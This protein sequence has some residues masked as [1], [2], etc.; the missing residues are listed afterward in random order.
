[1][2]KL[3][4]V[5]WLS[6]LT[7]SL[8]L[9][10]LIQIRMTGRTGFVLL[11]ESSSPMQLFASALFVSSLLA[12]LAS[13]I[14]ALAYSQQAFWY[15]RE[16]PPL[17][18]AAGG[19]LYVAGVTLAL[20]SQLTLGRSWRI[21]VDAS[22]RTELVV[23]GAFKV[24]RNPVFSALLLTSISLAMLCSTPLAWLACS[25][26][27]IA[28]ELQV[29]H[30]EEPYLAHVHGSAYQDYLARVGRFVPRIGMRP[31]FYRAA[32]RARTRIVM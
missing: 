20:A 27:F 21:G 16:M 13:P 9:R 7:V 18:A 11:R 6:Y 1:M 5:L 23:H 24:V 32:G 17:V 8:G 15:A 26:Q 31:P 19:G 4:I 12:G 29:R 2:P 25:V 14:L 30:V 22:E 28:L 3:T 10:I